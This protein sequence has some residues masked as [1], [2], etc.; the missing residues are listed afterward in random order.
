MAPI[1]AADFRGFRV[2]G[3]RVWGF[4]VMTVAGK[5]PVHVS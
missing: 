2:W 3:F 5:P 4:G 1:L